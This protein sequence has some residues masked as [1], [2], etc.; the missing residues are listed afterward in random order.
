MIGAS[1][2]LHK[3]TNNQTYLH[4]AER[5]ASFMRTS[6]CPAIPSHHLG[7]FTD[8]LTWRCRGSCTQ[9]QQ[10]RSLRRHQRPMQ[11]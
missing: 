3:I 5:F 6:A 11:G 8:D 1:V 9:G 2:W 4:H 7:E 10:S